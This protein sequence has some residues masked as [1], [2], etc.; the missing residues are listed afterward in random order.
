MRAANID[1]EPI[2]LTI[3]KAQKR[4]LFWI[5]LVSYTVSFALVAL[6]DRAPGRSSDP[7][8]I[9]AICSIWFPLLYNPFDRTGWLFHDMKFFY[10]A[11]LISGWINP[12]FLITLTLAGLRRHQR[13]IAILRVIVLLMI[14]FCWVVFYDM[15]SYPREGHFLWLFGMVL[16]L[17][18]L[19]Y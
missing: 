15:N 4:I 18:Y 9:A 8:Y 3:H 13:A 14:P 17:F 1:P 12:L 6:A 19:Q 2:L 5:G 10:V 16:A 7:G 11:L